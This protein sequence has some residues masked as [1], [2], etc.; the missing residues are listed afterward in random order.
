MDERR[1]ALSDVG[2][3]DEV[4]QFSLR[5]PGTRSRHQLC[6]AGVAEP[7]SDA[8]PLD[9]LFGLDEPQ[10]HV[11]AIKQHDREIRLELTHL[12]AN[13]GADESNTLRT[14]ALKF[15]HRLLD[16]AM[17]APTHVDVLGDA[18][19]ERKVVVPLDVHCHLLAG[20]EHDIR[21]HSPRP[22]RYPLRSIS[23]AVVGDDQ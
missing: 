2:A 11:V 23:R 3:L 19:G 7:G 15:V 16:A 5:E 6:Q 1:P 20:R 22:G 9:F 18:L 14:A 8:Q 13:E 10:A 17:L 12:C 21:F 4:R